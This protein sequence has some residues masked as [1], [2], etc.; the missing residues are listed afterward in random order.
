MSEH[1]VLR[2]YS[3]VLLST[4]FFGSTESERSPAL[5]WAHKTIGPVEYFICLRCTWGRSPTKTPYPL[6][7]T[8]IIRAVNCVVVFNTGRRATTTGTGNRHVCIL[9]SVVLANNTSCD[10]FGWKQSERTV[11]YVRHPSETPH[12]VP[13]TEH[14][15]HKP[16]HSFRMNGC[17]SIHFLCTVTGE[18]SVFTL[19]GK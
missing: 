6:T 9:V 16:V 12:F 14:G 7:V 11:S 3:N 17:F 2:P 13:Q 15:A 19:T 8:R 4:P 5:A 1:L 10:K 18:T